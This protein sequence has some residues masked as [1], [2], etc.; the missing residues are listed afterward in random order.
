[1]TDLEVE[2]EIERLKNSEA[3]KLAKAAKRL[4]NKRRQYMYSLRVYE[5]HGKEMLNAGI[6]LKNFEK[7]LIQ[8]DLT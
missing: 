2:L 7:S 8:E 1:M 4:K 6:T 5:K 3:V